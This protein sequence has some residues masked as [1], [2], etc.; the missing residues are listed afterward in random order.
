MLYSGLKTR[1]YYITWFLK[2]EMLY[3]GLK[4]SNYCITWF[5]KSEMLYSGLKTSNYCITWFLKPEMLYSGLKTSN[6]CITWFLK[7]EML[8]SGLKTSNYCITWFLK[9]EML[10]SGLKT[11]NYCIT[12][13]LDYQYWW[14]LYNLTE[15][16]TTPSFNKIFFKYI[17]FTTKIYIFFEFFF[18]RD[19][20]LPSLKTWQ[21]PNQKIYI[22]TF[23]F[24][25]F[26]E[27][28]SQQKWLAHF[29]CKK[30]FIN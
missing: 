21:F 14:I 17:N 10:Y 15:G 23:N 6:Y 13:F 3:S 8:Y 24:D 5:L 26:H 30:T 20:K 4:T 29:Y 16:F 12:W 1:N 19:Y 22:N 28:G 2:S 25:Y 18:C 27:Y 7:S 9:S 11:S